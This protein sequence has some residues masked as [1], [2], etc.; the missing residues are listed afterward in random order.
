VIAFVPNPSHT[1]NAL[2]IE[3]TNS[4]ATNAAGDFVTS[5]QSMQN[6]LSKLPGRRFTYFELLLRTSRV[7]GTPLQAE[8][9]AYRTY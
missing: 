2:L 3:G 8:I 6:F 5:E 9:V 7:A 4:E 1:A